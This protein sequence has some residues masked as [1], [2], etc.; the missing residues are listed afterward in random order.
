MGIFK[1]YPLRNTLCESQVTWALLYLKK[2]KVRSRIHE[3]SNN[4]SLSSSTSRLLCSCRP[5]LQRWLD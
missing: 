5:F 4:L 2:L 3:S 1:R